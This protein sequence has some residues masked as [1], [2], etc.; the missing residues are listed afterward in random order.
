LRAELKR[1][2][3][4]AERLIRRGAGIGEVLN[5]SSERLSPLGR[6]FVAKR[7]GR[8]DL[9]ERFAAAAAAQHRSCPLYRPASL[10][11]IPAE[12]YPDLSRVAAMEGPTTHVIAQPEYSLHAMYRECVN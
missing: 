6:L 11:L 5:R 9:A 7:A 10:A 2:I 12:Y 3:R 1:E 4:L 8:F